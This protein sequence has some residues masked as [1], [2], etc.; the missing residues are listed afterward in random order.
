M[1]L[2]SLT[3]STRTS[4]PVFDGGF[5]RAVH[6]FTVEASDDI[7]DRGLSM[8]H[9]AASVFRNPTGH[10][11]SRLVVDR[12]APDRVI[13]NDVVY[14]AWLEGVGSRN[15]ASRFKGYRMWRLTTQQL[16]AVASVIAE[17]T[18][19]RFVGQMG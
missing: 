14:N 3:T 16:Q 2:F 5:E 18:L 10:W 1:S 15:N 8:M 9:Q 4:G 6:A 7:A 12:S 19:Q 11:E 13:T 17:A